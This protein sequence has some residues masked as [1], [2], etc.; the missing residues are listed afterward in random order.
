M[1]SP[2]PKS[3]VSVPLQLV[4]HTL[5]HVRAIRETSSLTDN[6]L[7]E[8]G[9]DVSF[10]PFCGTL[11]IATKIVGLPKPLWQRDHAS[12]S[13]PTGQKRRLK[14]GPLGAASLRS[15]IVLRVRRPRQATTRS[16]E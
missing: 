6:L 16:S 7:I 3:R 12:A 5:N 15:L 10:L 9:D 13:L 8:D 4:C 14:Q 2:V 11:L 1:Q